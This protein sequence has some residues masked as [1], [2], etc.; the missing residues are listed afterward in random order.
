MTSADG[1][2]A[3]E[4]GEAPCLAHLLGDAGAIGDANGAR[5]EATPRPPRDVDERRERSQEAGIYS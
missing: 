2:G 5:T 4:G 1:F 3:H